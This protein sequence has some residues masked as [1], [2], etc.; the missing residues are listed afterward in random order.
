MSM[1]EPEC[2]NLAGPNGAGKSSLFNR[3][4]LP[5]KFINADVI[6]RDIDPGN[7]E[8]ASLKA[9]RAAIQALDE[10][11][12]VR[13]DFT[14]ETTLSSHQSLNVMRRARQIGYRTMLIFITLDSAELHIKR[15]AQRVRRGGH[16]IAEAIIRRRYS[17]SF[18]N[19]GL[20]LPLSHAAVIYD[21]SASS[22]PRM[23][24]EMDGTSITANLLRAD[25][26]F[27]RRIAAALIKGLGLSEEAI[28]RN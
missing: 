15:V 5:G 16:H 3:L 19:L 13:A 10:V 4:T 21:N 28:F 8:G 23:M 6:A 1:S 14:Y 11:L 9:G 22:G 27:D 24:L 25:R 17:L 7:P 2:V 12:T 26:E 18:D 20:A